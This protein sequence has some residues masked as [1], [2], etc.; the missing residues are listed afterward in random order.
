MGDEAK[1]RSRARPVMDRRSGLFIRLAPGDRALLAAAAAVSSMAPT[2]WIRHHALRAAGVARPP[3]SVQ[4]PV[5]RHAPGRLELSITARFTSEQYEAIFEHAR[6]CGL[7]VSAMIRHLVLGH[8]PM[9]RQSRVRS[10][11]AA[12]H[13]A[14]ANLRQFLH[15]AGTGAPLAPDWLRAIAELR[16]E[17][18][19]LREAL[20]RA[21]AAGLPDPDD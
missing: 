1:V 15:L 9:M 13:R 14:G 3:G 18:Q 10:A 20:L 16:D 17:I 7:T 4:A 5:P 6:A 2:A 21:D 11:I 12:V 8:E 19:S